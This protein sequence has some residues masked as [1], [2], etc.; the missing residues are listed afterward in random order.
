MKINIKVK[1]SLN[2]GRY[3]NELDKIKNIYLGMNSEIKRQII[4]YKKLFDY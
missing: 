3:I 1:L 4:S 2:L